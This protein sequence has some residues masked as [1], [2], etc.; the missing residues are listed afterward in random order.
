MDVQRKRSQVAL[1]DQ[2]GTQVLTRTCL[3]TPAS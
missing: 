2:D 1:P 3:T